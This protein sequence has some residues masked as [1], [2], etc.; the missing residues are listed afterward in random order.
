MY[1][2]AMALAIMA[3]CWSGALWPVLLCGMVC[4]VIFI[5][6]GQRQARIWL[7]MA[8]GCLYGVWHL[9]HA[10]ERRLPDAL[11]GQTLLLQGTVV[12]VPENRERYRFGR[13][14]REQ[15]FTF[16]AEGDARW[17]GT[18]RVR[19][20]SYNP[21]TRVSAGE[22]LQLELK[23][24]VGRGLYNAT[25]M[26]LAR[27]DLS[28]GVAAR[29]T[30]KGADVLAAGRGLVALREK[31]SR[32]ISAGA[33]MSPAA[34]AVLPALVVGDRAGLDG[35]LLAGF[36]ATGAAHLLAIS[37]LHVAIVA[38]AVWWLSRVLLAPLC[39]WWCPPLRRL[40]QQ[41]L[42]WF[43]ALTV[44][45]LYSALAGFSLPTQRALIMLS[46][47]A[48]ASLFR[49]QNP[50]WLSLGWALLLVLLVHPLSALSESLWLSFAAVGVIAVLM[51]GHSGRRLVLLLPL[52]MT[53]LSAALFSQWSL[54][55]PVANLVLIPLYSLLI[56]PL[57]LLGAVTGQA[58]LLEGAGTGVELSVVI[59]EGL[60]RL[61]LPAASVLPLPSLA[62]ALC[63]MAGLFLLL[64]PALPFPRH[65]LP[66]WLLP[67]LSQSLPAVES[68]QWE[69]TAFDVGQ[70]LAL[71][72]RTREHLLIYDTGASWPEGSMVTSIIQPW[73]SRY[74]LQPDRLVISHGDND[75][76]GGNQDFP[77]TIPRLS[78]EPDRVMG[79]DRCVAGD[80]WQWDGVRFS[81]LWP[82]VDSL[83]GN[84]ASCVLLVEGRDWRLLLPGDV[85]KAVEYQMLGRWPR[86]DMLVLAHH[87]SQSSTSA[88][89][90]R[91]VAPGWALA[92]AGY[93]HHFGHPHQEVLDRLAS[94]GVTVLRTDR[95]GMIVFRGYGPDNVPLITKWRQHY[96]RPWQ[97]P[98][99]W[100]FW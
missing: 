19:V 74:R 23:L 42:A 80:Q 40:T 18:H 52:L 65:L 50:L 7:W 54:V 71:A 8:L 84:D 47:M 27:H 9:Q 1:P 10:L 37:G 46:V 75:H 16:L 26:D 72:V 49:R 63:L 33:A 44:A 28:S 36:Q 34:S 11:E 56:I 2:W 38:G 32:F 87:G 17:P 91:E 66:L 73:L 67:W 29:A 22:R 57:T 43:P 96:A 76:A 6:R 60:T 86:V 89:L 97:Q 90:L 79:S 12:S 81:V 41:Q 35:T 69:L 70:G 15:H 100:R 20:A 53:V 5:L 64:L 92:S 93:R 83:Q 30:L 78:G 61:S 4:L 13:W 55:S 39:H 88:A 94:S 14:Q 25:G 99:G 77:E 59:M 98:V 48:L 85:S 82:S 21:Q 24:K 45:M 62:S 51:T 58:V 95:D 3:G 31:M 68:G